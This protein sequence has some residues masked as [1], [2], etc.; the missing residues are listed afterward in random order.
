MELRHLRYFTAVA[1]HLNFR[2]G[3]P[4]GIHRSSA[5]I[6]QTVLDLEDELGVRLLFR[7]AEHVRLTPPG[8][9][10][11]AQLSKF[12][13]ETSRRFIYQPRLLVRKKEDNSNR[14]LFGSAR[15]GVPKPAVVQEYHRRFPDVE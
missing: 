2:Q 8:K 1:E 5:S 14:I 6:S 10:S 7:T 9:P 4:A 11:G 13:D 15:R 3:L 12:C